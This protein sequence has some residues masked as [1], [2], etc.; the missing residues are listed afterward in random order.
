[1]Q[2]LSQWDDAALL[3]GGACPEQAFATFYRRHA[4]VL[5]RFCA[6][7]GLSAVETA[8]LTAETFAAAL[9]ARR[10][11][12]PSQG[13]ARAW[14]LGIAEHKLIDAARR[15]WREQ[16]ARRQLGL[17]P[18]ELTERDLADFAALSREEAGVALDALAA[19]PEGQREAVRAR[20]VD[21]QDYASIGRRLG[22]SEAAVRQRVHRG[23]AAMR[24]HVKEEQ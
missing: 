2:D 1:M 22:L 8:D 11:Y 12:R 3:D 21:E 23:L 19:L 5:L 16:S 24:I 20:V 6:R 14:L 13:G 15:R 18:I 7:R 17:E 9:L 10:R 4:G